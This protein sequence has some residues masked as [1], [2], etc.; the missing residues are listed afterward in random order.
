MKS[1]SSVRTISSSALLSYVCFNPIFR[2]TR[3]MRKRLKRHLSDKVLGA[4]LR[5]A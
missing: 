1:S 5:T 3:V 2:A 4:R